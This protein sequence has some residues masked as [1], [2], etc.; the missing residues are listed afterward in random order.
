MAK[1]ISAARA[2]SFSVRFDLW[3][4]ILAGMDFKNMGPETGGG[5]GNVAQNNHR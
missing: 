4:L 5:D 2:G 1:R 3:I